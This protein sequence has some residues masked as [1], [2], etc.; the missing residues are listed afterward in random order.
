MA[1]LF[2]CFWQNNG[3]VFSYKMILC[4]RQR[5][6]PFIGRPFGRL[7][8]IRNAIFLK[9]NLFICFI[10][11]WTSYEGA[12]MMEWYNKIRSILEG[13]YFIASVGLFATVII[14]LRQLNLLKED[15]KTKNKRASVEKSIE[16][17]HWFAKDYIPKTIEVTGKVRSKNIQRYDGPINTE[18]LFDAQCNIDSGTIHDNIT[19][20]IEAGADSL[21]N[22]MEFVSAAFVNGLA[23]EELA[24]NPLAQYY[25]QM[26]E[27]LYPTL[28][29]MR[30]DSNVTLY[31]NII[32]LYKIWKGRLNK[33]D[34]EKKRS[35]IDESISKIQDERIRSIGS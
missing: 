33:I 15:I 20:Y 28:C 22:E 24:F 35:K 10:I 4:I 11:I 8:L 2:L 25:C 23:D 1:L 34:L 21:L 9:K 7:F 17:L 18:F 26:V 19:A 14:G 12:V 31:S 6:S 27:E 32:R 13:L 29:Y 5:L 3:R 16:Y 30:D